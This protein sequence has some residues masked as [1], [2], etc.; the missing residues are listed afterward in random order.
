MCTTPLSISIAHMILVFCDIVEV[1][2]KIS[3]D[4]S[5]VFLLCDP[6]IGSGACHCVN[7]LE[8]TFY[9]DAFIS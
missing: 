4:F 9:E 7:K 3:E 5:C 2:N 8:S 6:A 1:R